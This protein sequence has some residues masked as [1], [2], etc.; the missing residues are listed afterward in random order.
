MREVGGLI[1]NVQVT[2][3]LSQPLNIASFLEWGHV[4]SPST[5]GF[6]D[7]VGLLSALL[8]TFLR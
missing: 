1:G 7:E 2:R 4:C 3:L 6:S 5:D 8:V